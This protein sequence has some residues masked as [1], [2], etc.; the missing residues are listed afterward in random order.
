MEQREG[1]VETGY[2]WVIVF[3]SLAIHTIGLGS[4]IILLVALKPIAA[5]FD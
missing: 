3:S 1:S 4:P 5:E 2:G